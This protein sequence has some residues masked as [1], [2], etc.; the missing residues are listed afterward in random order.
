M[1]V[2]IVILLVA[3]L[4]GEGVILFQNPKKNTLNAVTDPALIQARFSEL[5]AGMTP[6]EW[7]RAL[8]GDYTEITQKALSSV[9]AVSNE[10]REFIQTQINAKKKSWEAANAKYQT[11]LRQGYFASAEIADSTAK[12]LAKEI[13][14]LQDKLAKAK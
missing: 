11:S 4:G 1:E 7:S 10:K 6:D 8:A 9:P 3:I 2:L 12:E 13:E 5:I 14:A